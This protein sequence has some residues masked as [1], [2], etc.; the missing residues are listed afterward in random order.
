MYKMAGSL[1]HFTHIQ[2]YIH[3]VEGLL[4][5]LNDYIRHLRS[6]HVDQKDMVRAL[7]YIKANYANELS[8]TMVSN[9]VSLNYSY[10]SQ[11]F[12]EY[13]G[14]SFVQYLKK[15]RI[16]K[17]KELLETT[18]LKV[19]DIGERAGFENTKHFNRVFRESVGVAPLEYRQGAAARRGGAKRQAAQTAGSKED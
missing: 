16:D 13:A 5:G 1:Y 17:A 6:V 4:F 19:M 10:F 14:M 9:Y 12:K 11:A 15:L 3:C 7:E 8:M 18:E 2:D